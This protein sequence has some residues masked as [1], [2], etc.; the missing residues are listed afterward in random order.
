VLACYFARRRSWY[1]SAM[2]GVMVGLV[3]PTGGLVSL[4]VAWTAVEHVRG[5]EG[6]QVR[7]W[8]PPAVAILAPWIG[9]AVYSAYMYSV[10]GDALVWMHAHGLWGRTPAS[11][12][13]PAGKLLDAIRMNGFAVA[14]L[15]SPYDFLNGTAALS[16]LAAVIPVGRRF[17]WGAAAFVLA[18]VMIPLTAGGLLSMGRLTSVLF[19][20]FL[21]LAIQRRPSPALLATFATVQG[22]LAA[23]FFTDRGIF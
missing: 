4:M 21:W 10:T 7:A 17:G 2:A 19:P 3:R 6:W 15:S 20:V 18:S 16:A 1:A 8:V 14:V 12:W 13:L 5:N 9:I 22:L 11:P 23:L